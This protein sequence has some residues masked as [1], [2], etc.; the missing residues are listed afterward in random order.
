MSTVSN[1]NGFPLSFV[2]YSVKVYNG[3]QGLSMKNRLPL[4]P[5][6][7]SS[8][9]R[10]WVDTANPVPQRRNPADNEHKQRTCQIENE[11][12]HIARAG[13]GVDLQH[14]SLIHIYLVEEQQIIPDMQEPIISEEEFERVQELH[15]HKRRNTQTGRQSLFAGLL[16]CPDC[17]MCIRDRCTLERI[18]VAA[19]HALGNGLNTVGFR[20]IFEYCSN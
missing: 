4:Q 14:L 17:E 20:Q 5:V 7:I 18:D 19:K 3:R 8:F 11:I 9:L 13:A 12:I 15:S 6:V 1:M 10:S 2:F 16:Y